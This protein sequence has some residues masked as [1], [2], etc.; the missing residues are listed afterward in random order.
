MSSDLKPC[1]FCGETRVNASD[2]RSFNDGRS[3]A[4]VCVG[5][6]GSGPIVPAKKK[7]RALLAWNDRAVPPEM[8]GEVQYVIGGLLGLELA[9][10]ELASITDLPAASGECGRLAEKLR[11]VIAAL[12][13][14]ESNS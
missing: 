4:V 13:G 1:P 8:T 6:E 14:E 12:E 7:S 11:V 2:V 9:L 3:Y 10:G 5:C